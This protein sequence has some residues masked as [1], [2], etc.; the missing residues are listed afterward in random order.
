MYVC[1]HVF[2]GVRGGFY[3]TLHTF[4]SKVLFR[5]AVEGKSKKG[6]IIKQY[7]QQRSEKGV[8]KEC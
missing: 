3:H 6:H 4:L 2:L 7:G 5:N 8:N 1:V